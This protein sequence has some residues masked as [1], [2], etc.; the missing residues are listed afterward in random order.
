[1]ISTTERF[2]NDGH[3]LYGLLVV[4][5]ELSASLLV[6]IDLPDAIIG[7]LIFFVFIRYRT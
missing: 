5:M 7:H 4:A 6:I 3:I 1:M 2:I